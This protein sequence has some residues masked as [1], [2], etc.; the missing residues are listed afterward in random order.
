MD[1]SKML[2]YH[3]E[4]NAE[5]T[6]AVLNVTME[7]ATRFGILNTNPDNSVY[8]FEEKPANPKST[9]ASMGIYIFNYKD[10]NTKV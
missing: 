5:L 7:E 3:K 1:Y 2:Q 10:L 8:E 4:K 6:I 9:N